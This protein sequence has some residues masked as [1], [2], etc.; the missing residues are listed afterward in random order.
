[1]SALIE[2]HWEQVDG[3]LDALIELP[4]GE[5]A[6]WLAAR[7]PDPELQDEV[8]TLASSEGTGGRVFD[9][10]KQGMGWQLGGLEGSDIGPYRV[11]ER[12][13]EGG[14]ATVFLAERHTAGYSQRVALK[15]M[16]VGLY[17][18]HQLAL[19]RREQQIH[20]GLEHP[21]IARVLDSGVTPA[22]VP[23]FALEYV[24]GRSL[25]AHCDARSLTLAERARLFS[26]V[27][28]AVE[29]A[30]GRRIVHRDLK[31]S[32][33]LV[34]EDGT[35]KVLDFGIAKLL[36]E[37]HDDPH[38]NTW[39]AAQ[40][41]PAYAA[42]EQFSGA[43]VSGA[44]DVYA[45]GVLLVEL[46]TGR[47][48]TRDAHDTPELPSEIALT[49]D[50]DAARSRGDAPRGLARALRGGYDAIARKA[51]ATDP[52]TR[53]AS[54]GALR[55]DLERCLCGEPVAADSPSL[56]HRGLA[57]ARRH[58]NALAL[59]LAGVFVL[60]VAL[61]AQRRID[62]ARIAAH[63]AETR[64]QQAHVL[65]DLLL[66]GGGEPGAVG[67]PEDLLESA[68]ERAERTLEPSARIDA[69]HALATLH[70]R[71]GHP[72]AAQP[73]LARA[74]ALAEALEGAQSPRAKQLRAALAQS[75]PPPTP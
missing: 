16:R 75:T 57:Y 23:Y 52:A 30:H 44:T 64:A 1:V 69:L 29:Y 28:E 18:A 6:A 55:A 41:T 61:V 22:G 5:R 45:L 70:A 74:L 40:L 46:F 65:Q 12:I 59:G 14:M 47:R 26:R 3:W 25:T 53:Y 66:G 33:I 39:T 32:N 42:P 54:A 56:G 27:C 31:P 10:I 35:P 8:L 9:R 71:R 37:A 58:R 17:S 68:R 62:E 60:A 19:F 48:P 21:N 24:R 7:C 36:R 50:A 73:L 13:G 38:S 72:E 15:L 51:L 4:T 63:A 34:T 43:T 11:L 49:L 67:D 20:S 2:R